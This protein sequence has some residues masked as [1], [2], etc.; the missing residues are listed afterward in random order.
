MS[1]FAL[2]ASF[3]IVEPASKNVKISLKRER[4]RFDQFSLTWNTFHTSLIAAAEEVWNEIKKKNLFSVCLFLSLSFDDDD[5]YLS[6]W[7]ELELNWL[8]DQLKE[9]T[10]SSSRNKEKKDVFRVHENANWN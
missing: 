7:F 5:W 8:D 6:I 3:T 4:E 9:R 1:S 2:L 10:A